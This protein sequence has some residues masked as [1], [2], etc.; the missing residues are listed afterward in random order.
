MT[1]CLFCK[2][3]EGTIPSD[4]VYE[5][6]DFFVFKDINPQSKIH[7]LVVPKKH[8]EML[9]LCSEEDKDMLGGLLLTANKVAK[10]LGIE[11][12]GYRVV[13]N[14]GADGGQIVFHLHLHLMG[15]SRLGGKMG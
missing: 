2:I 12:S 9:T 3:I 5:D 6:D 4:K 13:I 1:D 10:I 11:E 7:V 8:I 15:G 14:S